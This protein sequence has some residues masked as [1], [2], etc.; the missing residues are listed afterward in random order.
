[1]SK[2]KIENIVESVDINDESNTEELT[3]GRHRVLCYDLC[4]IVAL[5]HSSVIKHHVQGVPKTSALNFG[6]TH[7]SQ[8]SVCELLLSNKVYLHDEPSSRSDISVYVLKYVFCCDILPENEFK[9]CVDLSPYIHIFQHD[10]VNG[11][12]CSI[13]VTGN[14]HNFVEPK[15]RTGNAS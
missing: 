3:T 12:S 2:T 13:R 11:C 15:E 5:V 1:M 7:L 4:T 8:S 10:I 14:E 9:R 6:G